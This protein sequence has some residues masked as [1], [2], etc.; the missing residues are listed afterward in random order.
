MESRLRSQSSQSD[1]QLEGL[2]C[3]FDDS[4]LI[5]LRIDWC[6]APAVVGNLPRSSRESDA[7]KGCAG[8]TYEKVSWLEEDLRYTICVLGTDTSKGI[9]QPLSR[10]DGSGIHPS[11]PPTN[12]QP[13]YCQNL[14]SAVSK[15]L[16]YVTRLTASREAWI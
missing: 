12:N 11:P 16:A 7:N 13:K 8:A 1:L 4:L 3:K 9:P 5:R 2:I 15:S 10:T 6:W 14:K